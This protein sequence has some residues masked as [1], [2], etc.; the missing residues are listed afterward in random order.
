MPDNFHPGFEI[1]ISPE[2]SEDLRVISILFQDKIL[3]S[4]SL[5]WLENNRYAPDFVHEAEQAA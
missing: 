2:H 4:F 5:I 3:I 1:W